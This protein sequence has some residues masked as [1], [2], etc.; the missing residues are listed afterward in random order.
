MV[1]FTTSFLS[2]NNWRCKIIAGNLYFLLF[3][4]DLYN[5]YIHFLFVSQYLYTLQRFSQLSALW[6]FQSIVV[7]PNL[8]NLE[9]VID[10]HFIVG[11][12]LTIANGKCD[13]VSP[14][15]KKATNDIEYNIVCRRI[16]ME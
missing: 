9:S 6:V 13:I 5:H 15:N 2:G 16:K 8:L 11:S 7:K 14:F 1:R 10:K 12:L 4:F 3:V